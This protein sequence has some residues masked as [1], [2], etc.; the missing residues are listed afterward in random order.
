[1]S[2]ISPLINRLI[3]SRTR[4][5]EEAFQ[6]RVAALEQEYHDKIAAY[7]KDVSITDLVRDR[8]TGF[9]PK[10]LDGVHLSWSGNKFD[11]RDGILPLVEK[12]DGSITDFLLEC[13]RLHENKA[14][15]RILDWLERNQILFIAKRAPATQVD[16]GRASINGIELVREEVIRLKEQYEELKNAPKAEKID[17]HAVV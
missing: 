10:L 14:I 11:D 7:I 8:L 15:W 3:Q 13:N 12:E 16:F 4:V 17:P 1:M 2:L 9:N 6:K 5:V